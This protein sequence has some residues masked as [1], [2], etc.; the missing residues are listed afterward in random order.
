MQRDE[1]V[2]DS[3]SL[4]RQRAVGKEAREREQETGRNQERYRV[5]KL[6]EQNINLP[7]ISL[8]LV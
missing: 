1:R 7:E 4:I 3:T 8:L 2:R 6:R 5:E